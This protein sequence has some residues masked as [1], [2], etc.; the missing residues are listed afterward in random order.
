MNKLLLLWLPFQCIIHNLS[1]TSIEFPML[2]LYLQ[3][4]FKTTCYSGTFMERIRFCVKL[5]QKVQIYIC[6]FTVIFKSDQHVCLTCTVPLKK[7]PGKILKSSIW[8]IIFVSI[9]YKHIF[10]YFS[11]IYIQIKIVLS[12]IYHTTNILK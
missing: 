10:A 7:D 3:K 5:P 1:K 11:E 9:N 4:G 2:Q 8:I 12:T 6:H